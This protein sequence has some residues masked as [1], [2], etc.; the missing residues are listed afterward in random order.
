M[1]KALLTTAVEANAIFPA[2]VVVNVPVGIKV[3]CPPVPEIGAGAVM[4]AIAVTPDTNAI[5]VEG[6]IV[7]AD[8]MVGAAALVAVTPT[9]VGVVIVG[10]DPVISV[11]DV[12]R[13]T[14]VL[15]VAVNSI[16]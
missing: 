3:I 2:V 4:V 7:V 6:A 13:V 14:L 8:A 1:I 10:E 12:G 9:M 16:A 5:A 11:P 15:P